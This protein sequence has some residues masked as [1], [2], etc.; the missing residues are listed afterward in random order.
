VDA[1]DLGAGVRYGVEVRLE[2]VVGAGRELGLFAAL[3][4][5][6]QP[7]AII[8]R[9]GLVERRARWLLA[10][11]VADGVLEQRGE[12]LVSKSAEAPRDPP[13]GGALLARLLRREA[14]LSWLEVAGS[15]EAAALAGNAC[16]PIGDCADE[17]AGLVTPALAG[18]LMIDGGCGGDT[19]ARAVLARDHSARVVMCD[20][21]HVL[22]AV[23][24]A[25]R[26]SLL[27]GDLRHVE[28]PRC[29]AVVLSNVLHTLSKADARHVIARS[30][31]ALGEG[32]Q[33]FVTEP[34]VDGRLVGAP[35]VVRFGLSL[36][37][38][39]LELFST[40]RI[41]E[42]LRAAGL[43]RVTRHRLTTAPEAVVVC[44]GAW[45][46]P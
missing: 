38:H 24:A 19:L 11:L 16:R 22:R 12:Q 6:E 2:T 43:R 36:S 28:L 41:E 21:P 3:E 33:L 18:G 34:A 1:R 5:P 4:H 14:P 7:S 31:S 23:V 27:A 15:F 25:P 40:E 42:W 13:K 35:D 29:R 37:L 32:G 44:G 45:A 30:V 8:A 9:L 20:L 10:A 39:D 46:L 17:L 26:A